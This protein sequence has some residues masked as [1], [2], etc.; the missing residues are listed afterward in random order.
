MNHHSGCPPKKRTKSRARPV[1]QTVKPGHAE[2]LAELHDFAALS[3]A[4]QASPLA[5]ARPAATHEPRLVRRGRG[6]PDQLEGVE[7]RLVRL[8]AL[9]RP[10]VRP[11]L[12][13]D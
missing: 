11:A 10:L 5:S 3:A 2:V 12:R 4:A 1:A 8:A 9:D 7:D 6:D 13:E